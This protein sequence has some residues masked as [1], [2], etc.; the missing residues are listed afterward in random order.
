MPP[1]RKPSTT[2]L[3]HNS[4][5]QLQG[6]SSSKRRL[7]MEEQQDA[8]L[9]RVSTNTS[10]RQHLTSPSLENIVTNFDRLSS[11]PFP[12]SV[13]PT[14]APLSNIPSTANTMSQP[15]ALQAK[16]PPPPFRP[17][18]FL[19]LGASRG[20]GLEFT[21]Q[22]LT[23]QHQVIAVVRDPSTASQLWQVTG[24]LTSRPGSCIIEQCDVSSPADID[25]F[26]SRMRLFVERGGNIDTVVLNAGILE[27]E[28]GLGALD[29]EFDMLERHLRVNC[30]GNI[31]LARK[32]HMLNDVPSVVRRREQALIARDSDEASVVGRQIVFMS[33]DSGSMADF[34]EYEDGF[35]AYGA[36]KA[37]LNMMLRHMAAELRRRASK[38]QEEAKVDWQ[39]RGT[40]NVQPWEREVCVLAM[41]PGEVS[42]DMANVDLGWEVE[43]VIT[44]EE[45][46]RDMLKVLEDKDSRYSGTFWRWDGTQHP[47]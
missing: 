37:A 43:G 32:L 33:S 31:V 5:Y 16:P 41:H 20:I 12:T 39:S 4:F 23:Q 3:G 15:M 46:V 1:K 14:T 40:T 30:V 17:R 34:R 44:A 13:T 36:S 2:T 19:I 35:A 11:G 24:S 8:P 26:V 25:A 9:S 47:W 21:R 18:T 38:K 7:A 22:L 10:Q 28:R 27:Y 42:T 45:S 29:V 6:S